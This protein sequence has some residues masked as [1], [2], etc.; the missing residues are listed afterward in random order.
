VPKKKRAKAPKKRQRRLKLSASP[1][2]VVEV[3]S[4]TVKWGGLSTTVNYQLERVTCGKS[5]C[6]KCPHGPYWY[7]YFRDPGGRKVSRYVGLKLKPLKAAEVF[8]A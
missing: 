6:K 1:R 2:E 5:T 8:D 4:R 7:A 3:E